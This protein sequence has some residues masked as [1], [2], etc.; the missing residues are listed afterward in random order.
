LWGRPP[1]PP[2]GP[3]DYGEHMDT[4][5]ER[6][7]EAVLRAATELLVES[8]PEALTVDGV[9]ARSGVA[10]ST[11]YRHWATRDDLVADV[12]QSCVP[13]F[14]PPGPDVGFED[15]L[16]ELVQ[17]MLGILSDSRWRRFFPSILLLR[18]ELPALADIDRAM[19]AQQL[20][21]YRELFE[22]GVA[23]GVLA[24][25]ALEEMELSMLL[26]IGPLLGA[27]V[28]DGVELDDAL[29]SRVV[30][31]FLAGQAVRTRGAPVRR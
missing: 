28:L 29:A 19:K 30:E 23:E 3:P 4:R 2:P 5:I 15:G 6:T 31:Q 17:H 11:V 13:Q 18:D 10:K 14:D 26:L 8:G 25:E 12:F 16:Q 21:V 9:V 7:R 1:P 22:K 24:P 20:A 27:S